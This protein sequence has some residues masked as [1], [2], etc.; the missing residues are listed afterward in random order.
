M[1]VSPCRYGFRVTIAKM[2]ETDSARNFVVLGD[3]NNRFF[4]ASVYGS[5]VS[6]DKISNKNLYNVKQEGDVYTYTVVTDVANDDQG[7]YKMSVTALYVDSVE[8]TVSPYAVPNNPSPTTATS[9]LGNAG[10]GGASNNVL[11]FTGPAPE[12]E[13]L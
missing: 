13:Y 3:W 6:R 9:L 4:L 10:F 12:A 1:H 8:A 7:T 11:Q 5:K 2:D